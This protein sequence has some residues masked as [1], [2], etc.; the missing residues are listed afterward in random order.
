MFEDEESQAFYE[1]LPE[2]QALVPAILL[3]DSSDAPAQASADALDSSPADQGSVEAEAPQ[4]AATKAGQG[5]QRGCEPQRRGCAVC[6]A[7]L[8]HQHTGL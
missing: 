7:A 6:S 2:L 5:R 1:A 3:Q 4:K 8:L